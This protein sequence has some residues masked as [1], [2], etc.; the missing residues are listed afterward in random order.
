MYVAWC[1][2]KLKTVTIKTRQGG[3]RQSMFDR[4]VKD[5]GICSII[6]LK[7]QSRKYI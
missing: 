1:M 4:F 7:V 2:D 3:Y 5:T 6:F